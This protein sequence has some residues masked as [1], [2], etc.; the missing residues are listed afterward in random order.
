MGIIIPRS[1]ARLLEGRGWF[2]VFGRRKTG[3]TFMMRKMIRFDHYFF[4]MKGGVA[5]DQDGG[6]LTYPLL[7]ERLAGLLREPVTVVIDEFQRLPDDFPDYLHFLSPESRAK[8]I[9]VGSSLSVARDLLSKRSPL[10]GLVRPVRVGLI[11]PLDV[12]RGVVNLLKPADLLRAA[13]YLRDPWILRFLD[14]DFSLDALIDVIR[15]NVPA[16]V[17]ESFRDEEREFTERYELVLRSLSLGNSTP[18]EVA[19]YISGLTGGGLKGQDVKSYLANLS[20]MGL[21]ER[22]PILGRKR[23]L[24]RVESPLVDLFYYL[25]SKTGYHE[26]DVPPGELVRLARVKEGLYYER[27]VVDLLAEVMGARVA[28]GLDP[29]VDGFLLRGGRVVAAVEVKLGKIT[30][31]EIRRFA[32]K[33]PSECEKIVVAREPPAVEGVLALSPEDPSRHRAS[34]ATPSTPSSSDLRW[35]SG[36]S[37]RPRTRSERA[38][39]R[40]RRSL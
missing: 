13:P 36:A 31:E 32:D 6:Q 24:Y 23:Y 3:K 21:V 15:Y 11:R 16:L 2:L 26:V 9:L 22:I 18:G 19:S 12:V 17:G 25:D 39:V 33:V 38:C 20:L 28:K 27:F 14:P 37:T 35:S 40:G 4:V 5:V 34:R 7:R 30:R 8:L 29:E 1:E 10:L